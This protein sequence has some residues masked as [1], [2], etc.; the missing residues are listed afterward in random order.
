MP[1]EAHTSEGS[2]PRCRLCG[3]PP[4]YRLKYEGARHVFVTAPYTIALFVWE[5]NER[6]VAVHDPARGADPGG[7]I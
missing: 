2:H 4:W 5:Y 3:I 1:E 6:G 7:F